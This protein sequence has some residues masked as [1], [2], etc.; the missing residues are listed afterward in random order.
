MQRKN[1]FTLVEL[2]V[3]IAIMG[4]LLGIM[5]PAL[6]KA[7]EQARTIKCK[8]N[9][10]GYG[11]V[12]GVYLNDN[13]QCFPHS[14]KWL[15]DRKD[16]KDGGNSVTD[17][18]FCRWHNESKNLAHFPEDAG[19]LWKYFSDKDIHL[20]PTFDKLAVSGLGEKH[21]HHNPLIPIE[22]QYT[23]S[24]NGHLGPRERRPDDPFWSFFKGNRERTLSFN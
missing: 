3:V 20:C 16:Y 12:M 15:Y 2:L 8:T 19:Q 6:S 17:N 7:R 18:R 14:F 10:K 9:L 13:N 1:A 21:T 24:M 22:P 11:R 5:L 23:Y 4:V